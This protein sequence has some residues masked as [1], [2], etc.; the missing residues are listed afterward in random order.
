VC[1][2]KFAMPPTPH[3][4]KGNYPT[5][6]LASNTFQLIEEPLEDLR[7]MHMMINLLDVFIC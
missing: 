5:L 3:A 4:V 7:L 2:S 1:A 6:E